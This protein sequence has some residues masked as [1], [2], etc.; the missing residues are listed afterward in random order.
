MLDSTA[1]GSLFAGDAD[2]AVQAAAAAISKS[3]TQSQQERFVQLLSGTKDTQQLARAAVS[4]MLAQ[5][6][7]SA[8]A[9]ALLLHSL[10]GGS[11]QRGLLTQLQP[12]A[13]QLCKLVCVSSSNS[14]RSKEPADPLLCL[15]SPLALAAECAADS[16]DTPRLLSADTTAQLMNAVAAAHPELQPTPAAAA[17]GALDTSCSHAPA[18]AA[19]AR[20]ATE[21]DAAVD[22]SSATKVLDKLCM[23][24]LQQSDGDI[25]RL[26]DWVQSLAPEAAA[27]ILFAVWHWAQCPQVQA[28]PAGQAGSAAAASPASVTAVCLE[29]YLRSKLSGDMLVFD[30]GLMAA[31]DAAATTGDWAKG[32]CCGHTVQVAEAGTHSGV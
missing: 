14:T 15:P 31:A 29:L 12:V 1:G 2:Q 30:I 17:L 28:A 11:S 19:P 20:H 7:A 27:A 26:H 4:S 8:C 5:R 25:S 13:G 23:Q 18:A 32:M 9:V 16:D 6:A 21:S 22:P 10:Q 3:G 24:Q